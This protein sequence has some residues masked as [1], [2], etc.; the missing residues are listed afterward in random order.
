MSLSCL[1]AKAIAEQPTQSQQV[2]IAQELL[3]GMITCP[4]NLDLNQQSKLVIDCL[5]KLTS[6]KTTDKLRMK[7]ARW[8]KGVQSYQPLT[9]C[10]KDTLD[11]Y[12]RATSKE[13]E[14]VLCFQFK[15]HKSQT[16][17]V[18]YAQESGQ[19]KIAGIQF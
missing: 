11:L 5:A 16:G 6:K 15:D 2:E 7:I 18:Y 4:K 1:S 12:P 9:C 19:H 8:A 10:N 17:L 3:D 14:L 13:Y